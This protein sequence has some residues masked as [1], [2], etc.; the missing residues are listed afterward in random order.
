MQIRKKKPKLLE[1]PS[2]FPV[3]KHEV[4]RLQI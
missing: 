4:E 2:A 1:L 3:D